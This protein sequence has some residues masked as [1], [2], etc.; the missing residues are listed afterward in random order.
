MSDGST[1]SSTVS[2]PDPSD[3][4]VR[5]VATAFVVSWVPW[6][7]AMTVVDHGS[8]MGNL[9]LDLALLG[10]PLGA[11]VGLLTTSEGFVRWVH[12]RVLVRPSLLWL[13]TAVVV[14]VGLVF[15]QVVLIALVPPFGLSVGPDVTPTALLSR[16]GPL[17][18]STTFFAGVEEFGWR[19]YALPHL[20]ERY[21]A[22]GASLAIGFTWGLWHLPQFY[23]GF[24]TMAVL[25]FVT[26]L[27]AMSLVYTWLFNAAG[28]SVWPV[29]LL[30]GCTNVATILLG[31]VLVGIPLAYQVSNVLVPGVVG[32]G[33]LRRYGPETLSS[34][35]LVTPARTN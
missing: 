24:S 1:V 28:G 2:V 17:V 5:F 25:S 27:V 12:D 20:Q 8:P 32:V 19:A 14:G 21:G 30:H 6:F 26:P 16:L 7:A 3:S 18:V 13:S 33:L 11:V 31:D 10:P 15:L 4:L 23:P 9:L 22:L 34:S 29:F 35:P